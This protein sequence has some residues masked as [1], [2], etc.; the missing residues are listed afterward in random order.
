MNASILFYRG[1][2]VQT[3]TQLQLLPFWIR[4]KAKILPNPI[5]NELASINKIYNQTVKTIVSAGR[6]VKQ[7]NYPLLIGAFAKVHEKYPHLQLHIYGEGELSLDLQALI[8]QLGLRS[9][10]V[11]KGR[12]NELWQE[13]S[14][15]D[16]FVLSSEFEGMPNVLLE[17]MAIGLPCIST[18]CPTGPA[19]LIKNG[20]N[21]I[22]VPN[23]DED[24]L[25]QA[26]TYMVENPSAGREMGRRARLGVLEQHNLSANTEQLISFIYSA[27]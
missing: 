20:W 6:L 21:G 11:L 3:E 19:E 12:S 4:H 14:R 13:F 9:S 17:A 18:D 24:K 10:A 22:L 7:K 5:S 8:D 16:I 23:R 2:L 27:I 1:C 25:T 15:A 26:I